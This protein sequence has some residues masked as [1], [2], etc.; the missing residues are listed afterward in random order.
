MNDFI[1]GDN[2][3]IG[4]ILYNEMHFIPTQYSNI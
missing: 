1:L 2:E 4:L 3:S